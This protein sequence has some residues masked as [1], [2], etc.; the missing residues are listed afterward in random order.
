MSKPGISK[1]FFQTSKSPL[2]PYLGRMI[3]KMLGP[4]WTYLHFLDSDIIE[5]LENN[6]RPEF[7]GAVDIFKKIKRGEH[8]ADFFRYYFLFVKGGFFMD[9]D[10]MI[11]CPIDLVTL[12]Y[13]FVSVNS[14]IVKD[15]IFQGILGSEPENPLIKKSLE[16]F[17]QN[18]LS[19]LDSN[20]HL[21]CKDLFN[22]YQKNPEKEGY[23]L[24]RETPDF[25]G[26]RTFAPSGELA[27]RH[28]WRNKEGIPCTIQSKN[29]VYCCV[30]YNKD[31]FKL[32]ELL[33]KSMKMYS[34]LDSFDFL[35]MTSPEFAPIVKNLGIHL[36]LDI[37]TFT[38]G[39]STIF[40]AACARLF[41]F[42]YP[43]I[44]GYEKLLYLDT[45]IIIKNDLAPMFNLPIEDL[46]YGIESGTIESLNF[47]GQF[48]DFGNS[49]NDFSKIKRGMPGI[50]S[51]TLLFF[52]SKTIKELFSR[53]RLHVETFTREGN[54][55]PYCMDQP[56][57]NFHAIKDSL[58]NNSLLN[59][60]VS[61]YE[62]NDTVENE[63]T[64]SICHFSFPIGNFGHKYSRMCGFLETTLKKNSQKSLGFENL[65][66]KK[67]T[68]NS[69][70]IKFV[71]TYMGSLVIET[72]W[73]NGTFSTLDTQ[74]VLVVWSGFFHVLKFNQD[75]SEYFSIRI[76]P[77]DFDYVEGRLIKSN[78]IIYGDS[79][80]G[81]LFRNLTLDHRNLF[82]FG[83]TMF[84][85]GRNR[86]IHNFNQSQCSSNSIYCFAFG[87]VDVR[88]H[89]GKHVNLGRNHMDICRDLVGAYIS[90]IQLH[91]TRHKAIIIVAV[92]PPADPEDH[93]HGI[94]N[95]PLPFIG[96]NSD[97]VIFTCDLNQN[98]ESA[99]KQNGYY[100]FNPFEPYKRQDGML[101]YEL[102]DQCI[103]IGKNE[104]ILSEFEKLYRDI[105]LT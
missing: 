23:H 87:E 88:A 14:S 2:Q 68:W 8:K 10:A 5:F 39:F 16:F 42:D 98:L 57:I 22:E 85:Q 31:Y 101:N 50:N 89:I 99:C 73:G 83:K 61:L 44:Q 94:H 13:K 9:S 11:Y 104:N 102:S 70:F 72:S 80:G 63:L 17:F 38:Q 41:I 43:K 20:Y 18:D 62:G 6:P 1:I 71:I 26:D 76:W 91:F 93:K 84:S 49:E 24:L 56:F 79:H 53:I 60:L 4:D 21:L 58:Y 65:I 37:F 90:T 105:R 45:D 86:W 33:L 7:P 82:C 40:Q 32:L 97:R 103:H 81:V 51:G 64:A 95:P 47:G 55:P 3:K 46:L 100:F 96:S 77:R 67:F 75:F 15:T 12:D 25:E 19:V 52:N 59:S 30:F 35:V 28:Y 92:P 29:L 54:Q 66:G 27:F 48:F 36:G 69:G 34:S 74:S 78:L